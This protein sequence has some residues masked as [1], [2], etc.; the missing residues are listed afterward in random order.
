M[1][2]MNNNEVEVNYSVIVLDVV[3]WKGRK[4]QMKATVVDLNKPLH[5]VK[6]LVNNDAELNRD[7]IVYDLEETKNSLIKM[8]DHGRIKTYGIDA[9][10]NFLFYDSETGEP[11]YMTEYPSTA[12][13]VVYPVDLQVNEMPDWMKTVFSMDR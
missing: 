3:S 8:K 13:Y 1:A 6:A 10:S 7:G 4:P 11:W 5:Q 12:K 2:K 9:Y